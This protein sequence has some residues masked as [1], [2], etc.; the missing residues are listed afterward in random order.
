M[1]F[2]PIIAYHRCRSEGR[3]HAPVIDLLKV[4][5]S[6]GVWRRVAGVAV[7]ENTALG[8]E[9]LCHYERPSR[10]SFCSR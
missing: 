3:R 10:G 4:F 9:K 8:V 2:I 1:R 7:L 5:A 6:V